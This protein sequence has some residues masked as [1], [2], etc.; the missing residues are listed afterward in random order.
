MGR[1]RCGEDG[2]TGPASPL[3]AALVDRQ[4]QLSDRTFA[5]QL[6]IGHTL[7]SETKRG[8][9]PVGMKILVAALRVFPELEQQVIAYL[10]S[11]AHHGG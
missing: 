1:H 3:L 6:G 8:A 2:V 11:L 5:Q 9:Y 7:W 4:G 10:R